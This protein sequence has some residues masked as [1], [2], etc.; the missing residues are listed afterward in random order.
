MEEEIIIPEEDV[1]DYHKLRYI[2]D[3][4]GYVCHASLGG[5]VICDLG[6][7]TEYNGEIP[8]DYK[9][10]EEW[11]EEEIEK[12]NAWKIVDGDL[13]FDEIKYNELEEQRK[14][15]EIDNCCVTH[16]ELYGLKKEIEDI[17]DVNNSQYTEAN[18]KGNI[19]TIDNVKKVYPKVKLTNIDCYSYN[20][21]DLIVRG[22]NIL[23]N[24]AVTQKIS[25]V[26]FTQKEDRSIKI[27]GTSTENIEYNIA[28]TNTNISPILVLKKG[29]NYYLTSNNQEI[30]MYNYD[31][32]DR[33]EIYSGKDGIINFND[34]DKLITHIVLSIPSETK[35]NT[36]IYPQL[37][38]GSIGT[39][40]ETYQSN[41]TTIDFSE[42]IS[43]DALFPSDNLFPSDELFPKGTTISY[44]L[45]ENGKA[46]IKVNENE[47]E[48]EVSQVHLFDGFNTIY[49]RQ[50]TH[51]EVDYCINNL[52]LEGTY[53]KNNNFRVLE[54]GSIEAHNGY[55]SGT[56]NAKDGS[57][58]GTI[59]SS[60]AKITGGSLSLSGST[61]ETPK[62]ITSGTGRLGYKNVSRLYADGLRIYGEDDNREIGCFG[63]GRGY[64]MGE[65]YL[66]TYVRVEDTRESGHCADVSPDYI[67]VGGDGSG[68]HISSSSIETPVLY[69]TS[70]AE[71]KKNIEEFE[72]ALPILNE[73]DIYKYNLKNES[74]E[75]KKHIGFI[76]GKDYNYSSE[77]TATNREGEE[78]GVDNYS[79]TSL[80][81]QAIK[82][83]VNKVETLEKRIKEMEER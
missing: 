79:M 82:E 7:C 69:Q 32:E 25:G 6:E 52:K 80:C 53:T 34:E 20:K 19:I 59:T 30:K 63:V 26:T 77:I 55:F 68:T 38:V 50:D 46:H 42:Y 22:K 54:D 4:N 65:T 3:K 11:Y 21:I 74:D 12:L 75:H 27:K 40:Y 5:L 2:L 47:E 10:I 48:I 13:V 83:L 72:N 1:F 56:V 58:A 35:V 62:I 49:T 16:K 60:N 44:I 36:T 61:N 71:Q 73:I 76:I 9:T 67:Y 28:G 23:P 14:Q 37:E 41:M 15:D 17:Q 64:Y 33:T 39:D 43:E 70:L 31:G 24:E 81:L 57:F 45:I 78:I 51:I 66:T 29:T 18:A 8:S